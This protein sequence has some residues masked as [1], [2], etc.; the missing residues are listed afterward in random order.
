MLPN[1]HDLLHFKVVCEVKNLTRAS[2][3]LGLSQP[4]LSQ[5]IHRLEQSVGVQLLIRD[6]KG[7]EPTK[8]GL[9]LLDQSQQLISQWEGIKQAVWS[10]EKQVVGHLC[11]GAHDAVAAYSYPSIVPAILKKYPEL[12]LQFISGLSREVGEAVIS[13]KCDIGLVINP[14]PHPDL[15]IQEIFKDEVCFWRAK[16][17]KGENTQRL[18][19]HPDLFQTQSLL[20]KGKLSQRFSTS[21]H[22]T[23][24][25]LLTR[26]VLSGSGVG[27]L[28]SRVVK[29]IDHKNQLEKCFLEFKFIDRLCLIFHVNQKR[30]ASIK[31]ISKL[32]KSAM[33]E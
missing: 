10:Q 26:L 22:H 16:N 5:A 17:L 9:A 18:L 32:I 15:V 28:P 27:I 29:N 20:K 6:K 11:L 3:R 14:I 25:D 21:L 8:P 30:L 13:G 2:E 4:A 31:E 23:N 7:V 12:H 19:C 33:R 24:L 1:L